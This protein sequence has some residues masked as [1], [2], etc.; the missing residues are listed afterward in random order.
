MQLAS[1][2]PTKHAHLHLVLPDAPQG[3]RLC[4]LLLSLGCSCR[5][6]RRRCATLIH[7]CALGCVLDLQVGVVVGMHASSV[8]YDEAAQRELVKAHPCNRVTTATAGIRCAGDNHEAQIG[9]ASR[10][11]SRSGTVSWMYSERSERPVRYSCRSC[12]QRVRWQQQ[13]ERGCTLRSPQP[14]AA[15][16]AAAAAAAGHKTA[17]APHRC[18][19]PFASPS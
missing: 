6:P 1:S 16:A 3:C 4:C 11:T 10:P 7:T 13:V 5:G 9:A 15:A 8:C 2:A 14:P 19:R 18:A 17:L 12:S